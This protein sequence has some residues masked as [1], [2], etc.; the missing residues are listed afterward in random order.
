M[1]KT[2]EEKLLYLGYKHTST[3]NGVKSY[4]HRNSNH[5]KTPTNEKGLFVGCNA[6]VFPDGSTKVWEVWKELRNGKIVL[7]TYL[8][9]P[10]KKP[11]KNKMK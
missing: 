2:T 4:V 11:P 3:M 5:E 1:R 9:K 10:P 8:R 7:R 6:D